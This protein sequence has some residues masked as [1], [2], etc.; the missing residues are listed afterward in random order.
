MNI[1]KKTVAAR[2]RI[3]LQHS[4]AFHLKQDNNTQYT[5]KLQ[6]PID[7]VKR[8]ILHLHWPVDIKSLERG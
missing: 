4:K 7:P 2:D 6:H 5:C 1:N 8:P 3:S